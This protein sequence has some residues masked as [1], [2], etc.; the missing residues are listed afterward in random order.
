V[1]ELIDG[2]QWLTTADNW[3]GDNGLAARIREHLWYSFLATLAA[4]VIGLPVGLAVGHT[5]RGRFLATNAAGVLRA[6]PTIGVVIL[7]FRWRPLSLYP[8]LAALTVL[9]IPPIV[10]NS[11]AGIQSVDPAARDAARG[12]GYTGWQ[13]LWKVEVPN[14]L[15]LILA[16]IRSAA[17]Q[18]IA[19]AAVAGYYGLGGLGRFLFLG[20]SGSRYD[21]VYGTTIAVVLVVLAVECAFALTQRWVVSPGITAGRPGLRR[22]ERRTAHAP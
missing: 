19:T 13:T 14:A 18:V 16:G 10:L 4:V 9:A 17:N 15:G 12:M 20:F 7:V 1:N 5:G 8:V 3:W 21:M 22:N 6:V 11:A 2:F